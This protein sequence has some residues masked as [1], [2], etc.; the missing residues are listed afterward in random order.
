MNS[1]GGGIKTYIV[2]LVDALRERGI[3]VSILFREGYD[4]EQFNGAKKKMEFSLTC[5]RQ[6]RKIRPEAIHSHGSWYCLLPG[7]ICKKL[8]GCTMVHTFHK[9]PDK[10][11]PLLSKVF[12]QS[13]LNACDCVT[14]VSKRLQDRVVQVD[15]LSFPKTE[16][17]YAGAHA[18]NVMDNQVEQFR[19]HY[20]IDEGAVVLLAQAM[21][22]HPLKVQGLKLLIQAV[23]IPSIDY[24]KIV[25]IVTRDSKYLKELREFTLE[26]GLENKVI[27]TG[28]LDNPFVPL[29]L[30]D[31][32]THITLAK[33]GL[34]L[35]LLEA[36]MMSK[37]I[38]A[39][40]IGGIPEVIIDR[41]NGLL[42]ASDVRQIAG[43]IGFLLGNQE[44]GERIGNN[45]KRTVMD[46][47]TWNLAAERFLTIY[48]G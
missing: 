11:L 13:L 23:K 16:I 32:Y 46:G 12:F 24:P 40:S 9:E 1:Y 30:C 29:R 47:F 35:A 36:M 33:G 17:T 37:P 41:E 14:F 22:V 15:N 34:S 31:I 38:V 42:V 27:F 10:K 26:L 48:G 2:N 5:Y 19:K 18:I 28:D 25:L 21:T 3:N 45:A 43:K 20:E 39:T 8:H 4:L 44:Y 7:V 6:L